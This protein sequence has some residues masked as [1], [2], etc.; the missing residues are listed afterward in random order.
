MGCFATNF[1]LQRQ[2]E[3]GE[4]PPFLGM[5]E[6]DGARASAAIWAT[7]QFLGADT[8]RLGELF[9]SFPFVAAWCVTHPLR[10]AGNDLGAR[11][12]YHRIGRVLGVDLATPAARRSLQG[13]FGTVCRLVGLPVAGFADPLDLYRTQAGLAESALVAVVDAFVLQE[14]LFGNPP[15]ESTT[16]L[17]GW[18]DAALAFLPS[19]LEAPRAVLAGDE[20]AYHAAL[21]ARL[22]A[23]ADDLSNGHHFERAFQAVVRERGDDE[24]L[25]ARA[26]PRLATL[27]IG[28]GE[29]GPCLPLPR[30][31]ASAIQVDEAAVAI[32]VSGARWPLPDPW[33]RR[34]HW[35]TS[36]GDGTTSFLAEPNAIAVVDLVTGR[37][38]VDRSLAAGDIIVDAT[39]VA[40]LSR[41]PFRIDGALA[42]E[43]AGGTAVGLADLSEGPV[44]IALGRLSVLVG[45][46]PRRRIALRGGVIGEGP[47]AALRSLK[48]TLRIE[49]GIAQKQLRCLRLEF[50]TAAGTAFVET[51]ADGNADCPLVP[52]LASTFGAIPDDPEALRVELLPPEGNARGVSLNAFVWPAFRVIENQR[53]NAAGAPGNF[54]PELSIGV[55]AD[56]S[57]ALRLRADGDGR[58]IQAMFDI[59]GAYV[60]FRIPLP[61]VTAVRERGDAPPRQVPPGSHIT[62]GDEAVGDTILVHSPDPAAALSIFGRREVHAFASGPTRAISVRRPDPAD[63]DNRVVLHR[64]DET[65]LVLFDVVAA[66]DPAAFKVRHGPGRVTVTIEVEGAVDAVSARLEDEDGR[67]FCAAATLRP[68]PQTGAPASWL[69]AHAASRRPGHLMLSVDRG[70]PGAGL[71]LVRFWARLR[72]P[73]GWQSLAT[74][75]GAP[76]GLVLPCERAPAAK[77]E[78]RFRQLGEW[79]DDRHAEPCRADIEAP[80]STEWRRLGAA[81]ADRAAAS[82]VGRHTVPIAFPCG[83]LTSWLPSLGPLPT[84]PDETGEAPATT[85]PPPEPKTQRLPA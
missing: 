9:S 35:R 16:L 8:A 6:I 25:A 21:F 38:L 49:T 26:R 83:P 48:A 73:D 31:A 66:L 67:C 65:D 59:V 74:P 18:Q 58:P 20:T 23:E 11:A 7:R 29:G 79:L 71:R 85:A 10:G 5:A 56:E 80:V 53:L 37:L 40:V 57:G 52:L 51:D 12:M 4:G 47:L 2:W 64:T 15:A 76:Y 60:P 55:E 42:A 17:K 70:G 14:L 3:A 33:P 19:D 63:A 28:W 69:S 1:F 45:S 75:C 81:V 82:G 50:G 72:R 68:A 27:P 54:V 30:G 36:Y 34:I 62:A 77:L 43:R 32:D 84:D 22:R 78:R 44:R 41:Q 39:A 61:Q 46:A 13:G 24:A